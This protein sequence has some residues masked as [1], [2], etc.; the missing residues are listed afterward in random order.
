MRTAEFEIVRFRTEEILNASRDLVVNYT[1]YSG[2]SGTQ[3]WPEDLEKVAN[4]IREQQPRSYEWVSPE[5][6]LVFSGFPFPTIEEGE[7][8]AIVEP[9]HFVLREG[10]FYS[11]LDSKRKLRIE[12]TTRR[13]IEEVSDLHGLNLAWEPPQLIIEFPKERYAESIETIEVP[14]F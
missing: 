7:S 12:H 1:Q 10:V 13:I 6:N 4:I 11:L 2:V 5:M 14:L 8:R 3:D 9:P